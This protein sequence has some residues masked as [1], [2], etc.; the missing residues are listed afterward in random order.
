MIALGILLYAISGLQDRLIRRSGK[1]MGTLMP[2]RTERERANSEI[3][4]AA[5]KIIGP[6]FL[7]MMGIIVVIYR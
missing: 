4:T 3:A 1:A 5:I 7:I 2:L 6:G